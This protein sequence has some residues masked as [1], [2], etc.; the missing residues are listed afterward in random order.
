MSL[1]KLM[2]LTG[3][4]LFVAGF[5]VSNNAQAAVYAPGQG[6]HYTNMN[7]SSEQRTV[8]YIGDL[9]DQGIAMVREVDSDR[10]FQC[11]YSELVGENGAYTVG[12]TVDYRNMNDPREHRVVLLVGTEDGYAVVKELDSDRVFLANYSELH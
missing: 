7:D 4:A 10:V 11:D 2:A 8:V 6:V 3:L 1:N 5:A 9:N 12:R